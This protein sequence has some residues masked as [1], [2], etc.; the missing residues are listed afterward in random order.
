MRAYKQ[1]R[2]NST[3]FFDEKMSGEWEK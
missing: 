1:N 2:G 3:Q